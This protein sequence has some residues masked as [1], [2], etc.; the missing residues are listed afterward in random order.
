S[1]PSSCS[2]SGCGAPDGRGPLSVRP[3]G[4]AESGPVVRRG[5]LVRRTRATAWFPKRLAW[6]K[7]VR[8]VRAPTRTSWRSAHSSTSTHRI[9]VLGVRSR[10]WA[11]GPQTV[12]GG[13]GEEG[14]RHRD[15]G[16]RGRGPAEC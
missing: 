16:H 13:Y 15:R 14:R 9:A 1:E 7:I 8:W 6:R 5:S 12:S 10:A 3:T 4:R 11:F 2:S